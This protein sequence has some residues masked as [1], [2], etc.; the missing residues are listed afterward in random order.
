MSSSPESPTPTP[1]PLEYHSQEKV[2]RRPRVDWAL[3]I[4][5]I[6]SAAVLS[7]MLLF[8]VPY[9]WATQAGAMMDYGVKLP[10]ATTSLLGFTRFCQSGGIILVWI[11]FAIPPF[12]SARMGPW[13]REKQRRYFQ[14]S[15][16]IVT[17]VLATFCIWIVVGLV[18]PHVTLLDALGSGPKRAGP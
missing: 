14:P 2:R 11:I 13:P 3:A 8:V 18:L 7:G 17:A 4:T 16:L 15:R 12:V 1:Q 9:V 10:A 6:Y 5:C